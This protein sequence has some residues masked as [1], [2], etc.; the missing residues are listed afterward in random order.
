[1]IEGFHGVKYEKP[2]QRIKEYIEACRMI[3]KR[4][5]KFDYQGQTFQ[6]PLP[7]ARERASASR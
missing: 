2:M 1:V 6:A 3:W 5:E 4:E 7:P